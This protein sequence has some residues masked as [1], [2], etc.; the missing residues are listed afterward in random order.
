MKVA[1]LPVGEKPEFVEGGDCWKY[2][3]PMH[4]CSHRPADSEAVSAVEAELRKL[5]KGT[6]ERVLKSM[7]SAGSYPVKLEAVPERPQLQ[8]SGPAKSGKV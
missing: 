2:A 1:K 6:R 7:E 8:T 3:F 5:D 4:S